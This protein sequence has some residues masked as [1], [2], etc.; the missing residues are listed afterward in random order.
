MENQFSVGSIILF[1]KLTLI[2]IEG[3]MEIQ[4]KKVFSI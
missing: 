4:L 2:P 3:K 1:H